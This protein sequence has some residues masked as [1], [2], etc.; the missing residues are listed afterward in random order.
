M[1]AGTITDAEIAAKSPEYSILLDKLSNKSLIEYKREISA[2]KK[3]L[4]DELEQI[5]PRID[6]THKLMPET[7]DFAAIEKQIAGLENQ[8]KIIDLSISDKVAAIREQYEAVQKKQSDCNLL[9]QK[10]QKCLFDAQQAKREETYKKNE[11]RR[12]LESGI[13][14]KSNEIADLDKSIFHLKDYI[15]NYENQIS[16]KN[17]EINNLRTEWQN[18][19]A[20]EHK[21]DDTCHFCE[22]TLPET[23]IENAHQ[24]FKTAKSK[25]LEEINQKGLKLKSAVE[26][27]NKNVSEANE[28]IKSLENDIAAAKSKIIELTGQLQELPSISNNEVE[29]QSLLEYVELSGKIDALETELNKPQNAVDTSELQ[30]QKLDLRSEIDMQK[31]VLQNQELIKKYKQE[32][33]DLELRGKELSQQIADLEREEYVIQNFTKSKIDEC[34]QRISGL[35]S[36]V[37]FRLFEYTIDG[38][39]VET[40]IPLVNGVPFGGANSAGKVNAGLDIIKTL[41]KFHGIQMPIFCDNAESVNEY[42]EMD[43]QMIF[44][45]VTTDKNLLIN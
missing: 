17:V 27:L 37:K 4:K 36:S 20:K 42:L 16:S 21:G 12:E 6:Q 13:S 41:Q 7:S 8:I 29:P 45:K 3:K 22:Q 26:E 11:K 10:R 44:L 23:M 43:N 1:I 39:E 30:K 24:L 31:K 34:E 19:S 2:R 18:E 33:A 15:K 28:K 5:Q 25:K 40:C 35:F 14:S 9:K 38:N 32:I